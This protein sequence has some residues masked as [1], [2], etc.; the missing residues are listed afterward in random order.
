MSIDSAPSDSAPFAHAVPPQLYGTEQDSHPLLYHLMADPLSIA[1]SL[2]G[3]IRFTFQIGELIH[4]FRLSAK[5]MKEEITELEKHV[6]SLEVTLTEFKS[7]LDEYSSSNTCNGQINF[8]QL[9]GN[10]E[11]CRGSFQCVLEKL[12]EKPVSKWSE[13][14][15]RL[16]WPSHEKKIKTLYQ[17]IHAQKQDIN[18]L[19]SIKHRYLYPGH[20]G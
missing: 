16:N 18:S 9:H 13:F 4:K 11:E 2:V 1:A 8:H 5:E 15:R 6:K 12:K 10:L 20:F 7:L 14:R 17:Q 3:F 19:L